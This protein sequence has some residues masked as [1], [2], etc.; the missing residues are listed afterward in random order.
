MTVEP[1][2]SVHGDRLKQLRAFCQAARLGNITR[3]AKYVFS[4][5]PAVSQQIRAL[6]EDLGVSLFDRN[7]S[8]ISLT[9]VGRRLF[10]AAMPSVV[11]MD[12]VP[13]TFAERHRGVVSGE[14]RIAAG[15]ASAAFVVP[16]YLKRFR[17]R[18][19]GVRLRVRTGSGAERTRWLQAYEVDIV[20]GAVDVL[21]PD[22]V[23]HFL[24]A[25]RTMLI[26]PRDHPLVG[27]ESVDIWEIAAWPV[28]ANSR[29]RYVR[30]FS[31]ML[32]RLQGVAVDAVVE[33]DGWNTIKRYVEAGAGI[34]VVPE[35]CLTARD[36]LWSLPLDHC[37]PPRKYGV[38][39]RRDD[40]LSLSAERFVQLMDPDFTGGP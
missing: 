22:L 6:E 12:R 7:G 11:G 2:L 29:G 40:I 23:S 28:V 13:D 14:L 1:K 38:V 18:Y 20:F 4:S 30:R 35:L 39:M 32:F 25:S 31:D 16:K 37:Y 10:R 26:T 9:P 27:R 17:D 3:A 15:G 21:P 36:R 19:P 5:Q 24:F 34:S 33:V 8:R